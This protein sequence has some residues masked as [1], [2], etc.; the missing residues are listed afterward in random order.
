MS[1]APVTTRVVKREQAKMLRQTIVWTLISVV[2][3]L[4]F[5]FIILPNAP[6]L[7]AKIAEKN[8]A[9]GQEDTIPPQVPVFNS[10]ALATNTKLL[11]V[12]GFAEAKSQVLVVLN[13]NQVADLTVGDDATFKYAIELQEGENYLQ[14]FS[15]DSSENESIL[16]KEY[17]VMLDT[18][19]PSL[20]FSES[21]KDGVQIVG[22]ENRTYTLSGVTEPNAKVAINDRFLF[23][24]AD[25]SFSYQIQLNEGDNVIKFIITD[26]AGNN[27]EQ[28]LHLLY[29]L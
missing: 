7:L 16:S 20:Q 5:L 26:K 12:S 24:R 18:Q 22:K 27:L 9:F 8:S 21:I 29:K 4:V 10:P 19:A 3:L 2:I 25:G 6:R 13:G 15:K 23:A 17:V 28:E 1:S 14:A 11:E